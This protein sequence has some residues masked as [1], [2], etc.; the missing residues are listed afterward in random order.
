MT[1]LAIDRRPHADRLGGDEPLDPRGR[2]QRPRL[3]QEQRAGRLLLGPARLS[4]AGHDRRLR[5]PA[6]GRG[7]QLRR[8]RS[9]RRT[10]PLRSGDQRRDR[11]DPTQR[12]RG[13][14]AVRVRPD[15]ARSASTRTTRARLLVPTEP[16]T[17]PLVEVLAEYDIV[18]NCILQD[19][20][21]PLMFVDRRRP[22]ALPARDAVRRRL[23][24]RGHGLRVGSADVVRRSDVRGRATGCTTTRSTTA[25]RSCGTPPR[26]RTARRC[27]STCRS[28]PAGRRRGTPTRRSAARSRSATA[29][30]S[31]RASCP[32]STARPST[33][34][35]SRRAESA[36]AGHCTSRSR[37]A[38]APGACRRRR[39][40]PR[41]FSQQTPT[42][43]RS[44]HRLEEA[45]R[46]RCAIR[47]VHRKRRA[48]M[49][50]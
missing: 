24:R 13:R 37:A 6:A 35:S 16:S 39:N 9:R 28:W 36:P 3:P 25:R 18:V 22:A 40:G 47:I 11:A 41:C 38:V 14:L 1:Q 2:L 49:R 42:S 21:D 27:W 10:R 43:E 46:L 19:T 34:T 5:P 50:R 23:L 32:S 33:R 8:H 45:L 26:G 29:S 17:R 30:S 7:D 4:V 31:T 12:G 15:A 44:F 20:D 48:A